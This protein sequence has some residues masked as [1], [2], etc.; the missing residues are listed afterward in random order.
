LQ[1]V[2][3]HVRGYVQ[4]SGVGKPGGCRLFRHTMATLMLEGGA[5]IRYI[6]Q[7][8]GHADISSTQV[9]LKA[10]QAIHAATHPR[11]RQPAASPHQRPPRRPQQLSATL[12]ARDT[13][14][15]LHRLRV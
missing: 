6:Q 11:R 9:S 5:D 14:K 10:L 2:T 3:E 4:R 12:G 15:R 8:L 13:A 7:M 1:T